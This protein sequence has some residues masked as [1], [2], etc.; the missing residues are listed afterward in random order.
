MKLFKLTCERANNS[1]DEKPIVSKVYALSDSSLNI[2][3]NIS[4]THGT[5]K[6]KDCIGPV[7]VLDLTTKNNVSA[8]SIIPYMLFKIIMGGYGKC[9][10]VLTNT[11]GI[12][13]VEASFLKYIHSKN[14]RIP[15]DK[16]DLNEAD[17]KNYYTSIEELGR[18]Y[19]VN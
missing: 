14:A 13:F 18:C 2:N 10:Y 8:A 7:E 6:K 16:V 17:K 4:P 5:I 1:A 11:P 15:E 12:D 19:L 9:I 3:Y